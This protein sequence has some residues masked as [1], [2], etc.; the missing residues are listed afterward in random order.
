MVVVTT[1]GVVADCLLSRD[2]NK[3][4]VS[5]IVVIFQGEGMG[6][7]VMA[8]NVVAD[9]TTGKAVVVV[10]TTQVGALA[11]VHLAGNCAM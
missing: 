7:V 10:G 1:G 9:E 4:R 6:S 11:P 5:E 8:T 2:G 3:E